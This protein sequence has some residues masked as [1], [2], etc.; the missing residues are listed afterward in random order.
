[1]DIKT[2]VTKEQLSFVLTAENDYEKA[3]C[4]TLQEYRGRATMQRE[5]SEHFGYQSKADVVRID[6]PLKDPH[7]SYL[8]I[9][10]EICERF[11]IYGSNET[12]STALLTIEDRFRANGLDPKGLSVEGDE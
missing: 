12:V 6:L 5:T 9:L 10:N 7:P 11:G 8:D 4:T 2:I 1:M 3:F